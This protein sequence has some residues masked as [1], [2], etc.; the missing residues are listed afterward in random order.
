[1]NGDTAQE[2]VRSQSKRVRRIV[3][4]ADYSTFE[5]FI[6]GRKEVDLFLVDGITAIL[7]QSRMKSLS[8]FVG[9]GGLVGVLLVG[10]DIYFKWKG[11]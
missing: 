5:K 7:K 3:D 9:G 2:M 1:M 8:Y 11:M 10:L 6:V 4:E